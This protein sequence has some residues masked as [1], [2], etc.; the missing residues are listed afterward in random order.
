M[1]KPVAGFGGLRIPKTVGELKSAV[2]ASGLPL[3][4]E[5]PN[6]VYI[7]RALDKE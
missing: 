7:H 4:F 5:T 3:S 6:Q 2:M 1:V